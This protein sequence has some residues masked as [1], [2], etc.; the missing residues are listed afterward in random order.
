MIY[1]NEF[2]QDYTVRD[3]HSFVFY[4]GMMLTSIEQTDPPE[5]HAWTGSANLWVD[6]SVPSISSEFCDFEGF[7]PDQS[8]RESVELSTDAEISARLL[9]LKPSTFLHEDGS[10]DL[11][12]LMAPVGRSLNAAESIMNSPLNSS[13][14]NHVI[15]WSVPDPKILTS[16]ESSL[17]L[18][19]DKDMNNTLL[20]SAEEED[21]D[22]H[23]EETFQ[24]LF[25][26]EDSG[27]HE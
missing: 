21:Q 9:L 25:S 10:V 23:E 19:L 7:S 4:K 3:I 8:A 12:F 1:T 5:D 27:L 24:M 11:G 2:G 13:F 18:S 26:W 6:I 14:T 22:E 20:A 16:I 17:L 15:S